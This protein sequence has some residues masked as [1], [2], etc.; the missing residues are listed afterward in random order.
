MLRRALA[1]NSVAT[2]VNLLTQLATVAAI[3]RLLRPEE[4]GLFSVAS[5]FSGLLVAVRELGVGLYIVQERDLSPEKLNTA[6][7][8][9]M[10]SSCAMALLLFLASW[11]IAYFYE[12]PGLILLL[13]LIA[14]NFLFVPWIAGIGARLQRELAYGVIAKCGITSTVA[15]GASGIA[16]ASAG[17]GP[18]SLAYALLVSSVAQLLAFAWHR[19]QHLWWRPGLTQ[20]RLVLS[21]GWKV[22]AGSVAQQA[23][24]AAPDLIIGK[25]L[26]MEPVAL[27]NRAMA[28]RG[29]VA[30]HLVQIIQSTM[31][32]KFAA[33][34]R[35]GRLTGEDYLARNRYVMGLMVPLYAVTIALAEPAVLVLF[36]SQWVGA[37]AIAQVLCALPLVAL[38]YSLLKIAAAGSGRVGALARLEM[39]CLAARVLAIAIGVHFGLIYVAILM[40]VEVVLYG[41][42]LARSGRQMIGLGPTQLYRSCGPDYLIGLLTGLSAFAA[43]QAA[44]MLG[45]PAS[46][47][48]LLSLLIGG[49]TGIFVWAGAVLLLNA[50][51]R[52]ELAQLWTRLRGTVRV[53]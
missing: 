41:V 28:L 7:T 26:G 11:P 19:P 29:L 46:V 52:H 27:F 1:I 37:I 36:G 30:T 45:W 50:P 32:P 42:I 22:L 43:A 31:V 4:I 33:E 53:M 6:L 18:A 35:E 38:P 24:S 17:L 12:Q 13:Q 5:A 48:P 16:F 10:V 39:S 20:A 23:G 40:T 9:L 3:S 47:E 49:A 25:S 44:T 2:L 14:A 34:H 21:F 51:L 15:G 8:L